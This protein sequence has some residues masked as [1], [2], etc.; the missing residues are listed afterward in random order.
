VVDNT[1]ATPV[2]QRPLELGATAIVHSATKFIGGHSDLLLGCVVTRD[3]ALLDRLLER[4][5]LHGAVPGT[6]ETWLALRG[7]RT[8]PLRVERAQ[9]TAQV[10]AARLEG[11]TGIVRVRYPGLPSHPGHQLAMTQMRGAGAILA[12]EVENQAAAEALTAHLRLIVGGTS[13]GGVETTI[14]RRSRWPG[15]EAIPP[16]LLRLSVG[17]EDPEDLWSDL[18]QALRRSSG[19]TNLA[20]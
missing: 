16:G 14:D 4:R 2:L 20:R 1:L 10:L 18:E 7:L 19:P 17:I 11:S 6:Q 13:L 15:E 3:D 8:L 12:F 5:T 9:A